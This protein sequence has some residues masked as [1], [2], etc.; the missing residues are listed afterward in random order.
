MTEPEQVVSAEETEL[1]AE[2]TR[3][4]EEALSGD[5]SQEEQTQTKTVKTQSVTLKVKVGS[6]VKK[7]D[8]EEYLWGVVA[9]EMPASFEEEA[10]KAQAIAARTYTLYRMETPSPNHKNADICTDPGCCQAW[11]TYDDRLKAWSDSTE[12]VF[13]KKITA[14]IEETRGQVIYYED[15]PIMAAFHATSAGV[16]K[17]AEEVWG[18]DVAYLQAVKSPETEEQVPN[19]YSVV[20]VTTSKFK[21]VFEKKYPK[22][23]LGSKPKKWFGKVRYDEGGL[24]AS[25]VVGGL[26]VPTS[27]L[28]TLFGLRS[29]SLT[30][31]C[32]GK[33]VTF[34]V[35]G[36]GHGVGMSQY[37]ADA[38]AKK[39]KNAKAILQH[40]Y[41]GVEIRSMFS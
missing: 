34:Y 16:T 20:K 5:T 37:G 26:K 17:S 33:N 38:L 29:S 31:E 11:I 41:T 28:R 21:E 39:G 18:K 1:T 27:T 7:M 10:L 25:I 36:Y 4:E 13:A 32:D 40:Y 23:E 12:K 3:P 19:Y 30:I 9:A 8:L 22:A 24:P 2:E 35:T 6:K 15:K 14:A